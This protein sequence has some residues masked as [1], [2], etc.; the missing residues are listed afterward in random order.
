MFL[1]LPCKIR[2]WL[3]ERR[4]KSSVATTPLSDTT[5]KSLQHGQPDK[6]L[7]QGYHHGRTALFF[8]ATAKICMSVLEKRDE[9]SGHIV[10]GHQFRSESDTGVAS[11]ERRCL[12]IDWTKAWP[13]GGEQD[14]QGRDCRMETT[15]QGIP[16]GAAWITN[17]LLLGQCGAATESTRSPIHRTSQRRLEETTGQG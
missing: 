6:Y 3:S 4:P 8:K 17:N 11:S 9:R 10:D 5:E 1:H 2:S 12:P 15:S 14:T 7:R 16:P 13:S